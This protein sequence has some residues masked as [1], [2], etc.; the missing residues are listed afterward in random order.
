MV[1][2]RNPP[3]CTSTREALTTVTMLKQY[4]LLGRCWKTMT[5]LWWSVQCQ[6]GIDLSLWDASEASHKVCLFWALNRSWLPHSDSML[7]SSFLLEYTQGWICTECFKQYISSLLALAVTSWFRPLALV[8]RLRTLTCAPHFF[9]LV[10][11]ACML[12]TSV[13]H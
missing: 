5:G 8:P 6:T 10:C 1:T 12:L 7:C 3:H 13:G 4:E 11:T 2:L 9:P